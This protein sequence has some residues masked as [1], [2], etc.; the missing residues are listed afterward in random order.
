[1]RYSEPLKNGEPLLAECDQRGHED[2]VSKRKH[3]SYKWGKRDWV[4]VKCAPWK[5]D[6][7]DR[8]DLFVR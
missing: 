8:G 2:I 3:F 5:D 4:K 7:K 1:V 6:N